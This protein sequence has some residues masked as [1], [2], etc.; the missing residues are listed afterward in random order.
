MPN[1]L[2]LLPDDVLD[3]IYKNVSMEMYKEVMKEL[4]YET[5]CPHCGLYGV[6]DR[7]LE[8]C[9]GCLDKES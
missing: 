8:L 7:Y 9:I 6:Y 3:K 5:D 4:K 1:Y 2:E